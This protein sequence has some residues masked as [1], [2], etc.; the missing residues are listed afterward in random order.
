[1]ITKLNKEKRSVGESKQKIEENIQAME[2]KCNHLNKVKAKLE[3]SLDECEDSLERE[4][5]TKSDV[6]KLKRKIEGDHKLTQEA[7]SDLERVKNE[8]TQNIQRKDKEISSMQA[9]IEDEQTLG[10]TVP[11]GSLISP[12]ISKH[13]WNYPFIH[14]LL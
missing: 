4:K 3:Q 5:K 11:G 1:M 9:K 6:E 2:D 13:L 12:S 8:L 7:T 10:N 14:T